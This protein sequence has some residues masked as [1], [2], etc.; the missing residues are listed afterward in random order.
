[1]LHLSLL[2]TGLLR[3]EIFVEKDVNDCIERCYEWVKGRD[4]LMNPGNEDLRTQPIEKLLDRDDFTRYVHEDSLLAPYL[5]EPDKI[6]YAYKCIGSAILSL[7][8]AMRKVK[9][10][11]PVEHEN[12]F[13]ELTI[14]MVMEGGDADTNGAAAC[15]VFLT[16]SEIPTTRHVPSLQPPLSNPLN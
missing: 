8:R 11:D 2:I 10:Y 12:I 4:D 14:D 9:D 1:M 6:G 13:E 7:R 5:D 16:T 3:G 15:A